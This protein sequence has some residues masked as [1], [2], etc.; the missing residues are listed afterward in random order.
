MI[1]GH[2]HAILP[3]WPVS[4]P[5]FCSGSD[6]VVLPPKWQL[7]LCLDVCWG[8]PEAYPRYCEVESYLSRKVLHSSEH[9]KC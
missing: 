7:S 3:P 5:F 8:F 2:M 6:I 4:S 1:V 9:R